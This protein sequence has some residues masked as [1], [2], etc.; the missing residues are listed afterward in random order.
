MENTA[1]RW[2][3]RTV[4]GAAGVAVA[5]LAVGCGGSG[6]PGSVLTLPGQLEDDDA[7]ANGGDSAPAATATAPP[8]TPTPTPVPVPPAGRTTRVLLEGTPAETELVIAHSGVRG[9]AVMFLGG[10]HGNEPGGWL[11]AEEIATWAP[12]AGSLLVLPHANVR[13]IA[14]FVRTF[15][16]IGDLNRLY[17][18]AADSEFLMERMAA[19]IVAV[20]REHRVELLLDLHESWAFYAN[21]PQNGTAFLGQTVSAGVGPRNPGFVSELVTAVNPG[22]AVERDLLIPRDGAAF[23]RD[24]QA[25]QATN[26]GRSSLSL[27]GHVPGLTPILVEM[28]QEDQAIERRVELHLAVAESALRITGVM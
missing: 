3:R 26:R 4:L 20:A 15:D 23:R 14:S 18:G 7:G 11:A 24:D 8:P 22:L 19:E 1:R 16:D 17:P 5:G 6:K 10:V 21:R 27:G 25:P 28:G 2:S 13:A 12:A 9:P